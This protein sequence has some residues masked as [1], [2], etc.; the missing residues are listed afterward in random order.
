[1]AEDRFEQLKLKYRR[2]QQTL[3]LRIIVFSRF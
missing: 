2:E 1:M 3:V